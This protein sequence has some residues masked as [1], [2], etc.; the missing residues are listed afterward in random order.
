MKK[1]FTNILFVLL[2]SSGIG[3]L[4]YPTVSDLWNSYHQS[5]AISTYQKQVEKLDTTET[6]SMLAAAEAYNQALEKGVVPTYHLT[7]ED[8]KK[9]NSLLDV[10]STGIMGHVEIPKLGTKLPIYHGTDEAILQVAIGHIP[11]SSLPSGGQGTHSVI[12]GHRGLPSAKLFT[13]IDQLKNG[14]HFKLH[15]LGRTVTYQVDQ[16]LTV[17]PDDV[18]S[19]TIDPNQDYCTLV[20]CTP[21]GVNTHRL[22]V[23]GHRIPNEEEPTKSENKTSDYL[24]WHYIILLICFVFVLFAILLVWLLS[25]RRRKKR[26]ELRRKTG[27]RSAGYRRRIKKGRHAK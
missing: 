11:G 20:T 26:A 25:R 5:Q 1:H 27:L 9:Y 22:L 18:S 4:L 19:L 2:L 21:Y 15:V 8:K 13:D 10:T 6:E 14:D 17:E 7:E 24:P 23:R 3:L 16:T 12:S